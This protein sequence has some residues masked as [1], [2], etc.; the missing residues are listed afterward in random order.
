MVS[1]EN[2]LLCM[3]QQ[4]CTHFK[5][6][7]VLIFGGM[8]FRGIAADSKFQEKW[9]VLIFGGELIYE[10]LRYSQSHSTPILVTLPLITWSFPPHSKVVRRRTSV[11]RTQAGDVLTISKTGEDRLCSYWEELDKFKCQEANCRE[12]TLEKSGLEPTAPNRLA[13]RKHCASS[14]QPNPPS[15]NIDGSLV[16]FR[17]RFLGI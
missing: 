8:Y 3:F 5:D 13:D 16:N 9:R 4:L 14:T 1:I 6:T 17:R 12:K 7:G 11:G 10:V 2:K 15:T